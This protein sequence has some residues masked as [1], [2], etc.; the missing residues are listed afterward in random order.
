MAL[1]VP[2]FII[3]CCCLS[4]WPGSVLFCMGCRTKGLFRHG[5]VSLVLAVSRVWRVFPGKCYCC[6]FKKA[7]LELS[8]R[9]GSFDT[10]GPTSKSFLFLFYFIY[11][12]TS[13]IYFSRIVLP[14]ESGLLLLLLLL[15][16]IC[17]R[18]LSYPS[19]PDN[20]LPLTS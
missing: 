2:P 3:H 6:D 12:F 8:P 1:A 4:F 20:Q 15:P 9:K 10:P 17:S 14:S 11:L 5:L 19:P 13:S 18:P 16:V 7:Q